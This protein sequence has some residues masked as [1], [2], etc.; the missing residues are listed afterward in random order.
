MLQSQ[1]DCSGQARRPVG[2]VDR[3]TVLGAGLHIDLEAALVVPV[4]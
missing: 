1:Q 4:L 3:R 2:L